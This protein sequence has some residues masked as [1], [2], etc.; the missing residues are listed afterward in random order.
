MIFFCEKL[1]TI[2][3][4]IVIVFLCL[5]NPYR[6]CAQSL[7]SNEK[8]KAPLDTLNVL[9]ELSSVGKNK[10]LLIPKVELT[11]TN[12][13]NPLKMHVE[14]M[15]VFNIIAA[16][17]SPDNVIPGF[18]YNDGL[19]WIPIKLPVDLIGDI[20][21]SAST[22]DHNGWYLLNG[23]SVNDL[24]SVAKNNAIKLGFNMLLPN[25][26][27]C[28]LKAKTGKE[29]LGSI[30]T[31]NSPFVLTKDNLP[32]FNFSG[33]TNSV[34]HVHKFNNPQSFGG[35][36]S[37]TP[38]EAKGKSYS[39]A[40]S[41]SNETLPAEGHSHTFQVSN[42]GGGQPITFVPSYYVTNIFIFLGK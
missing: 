36:R 20:K 12:S 29:T 14:G 9:L 25:A 21:H 26:A 6:G 30:V 3:Y 37:T 19:K 23:R 33:Q 40:T 18:Y 35:R 39:T 42:G 5:L 10:G 11:S 15:T 17:I 7:I 41:D 13:P 8:G 27:D 2:F 22:I 1:T 4:L 28:F 34:S 32:D 31:G 24:P 16:G 38:I